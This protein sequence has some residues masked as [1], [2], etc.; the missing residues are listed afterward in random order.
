M[1]RYVLYAM[2]ASLYSAK[3][4]AYLRKQRIDYIERAPGDARYR[5]HRPRS[6]HRVQH[7]QGRLGVPQRRQ[8]YAGCHTRR[9]RVD[10]TPAE[11]FKNRLLV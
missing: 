11:R 7:S 2:P 10:R 8:C 6:G 5:E 4:R 3:A 9:E 1:G